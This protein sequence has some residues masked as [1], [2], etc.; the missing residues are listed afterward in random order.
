M[1]HS[2][3][4]HLK[5]DLVINAGTAGGF[6]QKGGR[7]GDV[8]IGT[9]HAHHDRRIPIPGFSDYGRGNHKA[10]NVSKLIRVSLLRVK[11]RCYLSSFVFFDFVVSWVQDWSNFHF[12]FPRSHRYR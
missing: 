10:L 12:Q 2:A 5:P 3:I 11:K 1:S 9:L 6:K 7:V 8:Y 4:T